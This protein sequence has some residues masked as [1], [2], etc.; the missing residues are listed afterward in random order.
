MELNCNIVSGEMLQQICDIYIAKENKINANPVISVQKHKWLNIDTIPD[1]YDNPSII[2]VYSETIHD[3]F[4]N[5]IHKFKNKFILL[6]HNSDENI[7]ESYRAYADHPLLVH[8]FAQNL[9][10]RHP[11][12]SILPIGVA[13]TQWDHGK[14]ELFQNLS[15]IEFIK[16]ENIVYFEFNVETNKSKREPCRDIIAKHFPFGNRLSSPQYLNKIL[17]SKFVISP[18]GNGIDCHRIWETLLVGSVPVVSRS[19]FTEELE[20]EFP[21][22]IIDNWEQVTPEFL[23]SKISTFSSM[24]WPINKLDYE[25]YKNIIHKKII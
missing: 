12:I 1:I 21:I 16:K 20:K 18:E 19:I 11:K 2:F 8:W 24:E 25:Y 22:L 13:N 17:N 10:I 15:K 3:F 23:E 7:D 9:N 14:R 6:S 4:K 5:C